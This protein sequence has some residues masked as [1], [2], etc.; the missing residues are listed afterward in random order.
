M[1]VEPRAGNPDTWDENDG[2]SPTIAFSKLDKPMRPCNKLFCFVSGHEFSRAV[3]P[4]KR[5]GL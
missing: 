5:V 3:K 4:Q 1:L 2:R